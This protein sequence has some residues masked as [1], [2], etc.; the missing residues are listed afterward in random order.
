MCG[1][2][3]L[4]AHPYHE[5]RLMMAYDGGDESDLESRRSG[6][7]DKTTIDRLAEPPIHAPPQIWLDSLQNEVF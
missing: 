6:A 2:S 4:V 5:V 7:V 3:V 1:K